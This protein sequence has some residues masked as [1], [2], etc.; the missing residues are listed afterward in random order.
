MT[1]KS[2]E[3]F[4]KK[5]ISACNVCSLPPCGEGTSLPFEREGDKPQFYEI[6][7]FPFCVIN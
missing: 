3:Y 6:I 7:M 4:L 5:K 1:N 2:I